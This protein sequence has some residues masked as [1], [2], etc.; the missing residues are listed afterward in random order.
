MF[1]HQEYFE[2][3]GIEIDWMGHP[4]KACLILRSSNPCR[5]KWVIV[6]FQ[7]GG[8]DFH[9]KH[10][11]VTVSV[12]RKNNPRGGG[13]QFMT[14]KQ[15]IQW[16]QLEYTISA[17]LHKAKRKFRVVRLKQ[18]RELTL[19]EMFVSTHDAILSKVPFETKK[20]LAISLD[21]RISTEE[22]HNSYQAVISVL[23]NRFSKVYLTFCEKFLGPFLETVEFTNL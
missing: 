21:P 18:E 20:S 17:W 5:H 10:Y 3:N 2:R 9:P 6:Q 1:L 19:W 13:F 22:R 12:P 8:P 4:Q 15:R 23:E 7:A 16:D 14:K 11:D